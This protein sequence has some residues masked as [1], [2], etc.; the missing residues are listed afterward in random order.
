MNVSIY[1][2]VQVQ[3]FILIKVPRHLEDL[4]KFSVQ[5]SIYEEV[6]SIIRIY[7]YLVNL[8]SLNSYWVPFVAS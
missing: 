6:Y 2:L 3:E 4:E 5:T 1:N 7:N 8:G